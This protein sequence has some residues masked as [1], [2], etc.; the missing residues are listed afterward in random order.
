MVIARSQKPVCGARLVKRLLYGAVLAEYHAAKARERAFSERIV[1]FAVGF[2]AL[3]EGRGLAKK[4]LLHV[5]VA[6]LAVD[7]EKLSRLRG[8]MY[9][10]KSL[11]VV[12]K[13]H[14]VILRG[15][16]HISEL[17]LRT[18]CFVFR[19]GLF[20][21]VFEIVLTLTVV[22]HRLLQGKMVGEPLPIRPI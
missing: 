12:L 6:Y 21:F 13:R 10:L 16:M 14:G 11:F 22:R 1:L 7:S 2:R 15:E 8:N 3:Q 19:L 17:F 5:A 9:L 18:Y 20:L 4:A